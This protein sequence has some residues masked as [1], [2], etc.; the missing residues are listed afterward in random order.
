MLSTAVVMDLTVLGDGPPHLALDELVWP[1]NYETY[2]DL[3]RSVIDTTTI[4]LRSLYL[5]EDA[6]AAVRAKTYDIVT[7]LAFIARVALDIANAHRAGRTLRYDPKASP[8]LAFL[9]KGGDPAKAPVPRIWHHPVNLGPRARTR[10]AVR[11]TRSRVL[12][13]RAGRRRIDVHNR[14]NLVN[15]LLSEDSRPAVDWPV[16]DIDWRDGAN[17]KGALQESLAALSSSYAEAIARHIDDADLRTTLAALGKHLLAYHLAKGWT[18]FETFVRHIR[19]RPMG[20]ML[21]GGTPKHLGRLA[22]WLYRREGRPVVRCAHGGERV[23]F[24]DYE[25]GLAEFPDCDIYYAHSAGERDALAARLASGAAALVQPN[26]SVDIRTIGSAYHQALHARAQNRGRAA[27]T[28]T[29]VYVA[30]GYLGEQLGDFPNRKPPDPLYLDW[31][32]DLVLAIKA[33]GYRVLVK[34]HPAGIAHERRFLGPYTDGELGGIFDPAG[35][36][37]DALV[38]DFAG[39]AFFDAMAT[40]IPMVYADMCVRPFDESVRDD[41]LSRCPIAPAGRDARGRFRVDR[42]ALGGALAHAVEMDTCPP[43]FHDRYFGT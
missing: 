30:G 36:S 19:R 21:V 35:V 9:S 32:I 38:F 12:A 1:S 43:G 20:E 34:P 31:Q 8:M 29:V 11:R 25:W 40:N 14:N 6:A 24:S 7:D 18:D 33:L 26:M 28:G 27:K 10:K 41:F 4:A 13:R 16:T 2:H 3:S 17:L 15:A 22:G 37:A 42:D 5:P 39:T 23:F